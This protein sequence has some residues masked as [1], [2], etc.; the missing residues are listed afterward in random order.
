M[1]PHTYLDRAYAEIAR[2]LALAGAGRTA[3]ARTVLAAT[4]EE[5]DD[6]GDRLA[7]AITRLVDASVAEQAG[8]TDA[9]TAREV[10]EAR[11]R[12]LGIQATGWRHLLQD[13]LGLVAS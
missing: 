10:A 4:I 5:L 7:Q 3:D 1:L 6:T 11:L 9:A 2:A 8:R 12:E 13:S